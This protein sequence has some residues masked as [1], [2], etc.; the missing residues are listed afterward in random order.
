MSEAQSPLHRLSGLIASSCAGAHASVRI[1]DVEGRSV[2]TQADAQGVY[3]LDL[4]P[5]RAPLLISACL[6]AFSANVADGDAACAPWARSLAALVPALEAGASSLAHVNALT[7]WI[8]SGVAQGLGFRGPQGLVEQGSSAGVTLAAIAQA[9]ENLQPLIRPALL[10]LGLGDADFDPVSVPMRVQCGPVAAAL[11]LLVLNRGFHNDTGLP[12]ATLLFD[13]DYR[14]IGRVDAHSAP[15]PLDL[16]HARRARARQRD[17]AT[18]RL[19]IVGDSTAANYERARFPRTGWGQVLGEV[20]RPEV[21]VVNAAK[22]GRSSRSFFRQAY[23]AQLAP[24]MRPGDYL[25]INF[26]HNDQSADAARP[27]RGAADL[28]HLAT[29]PDDAV[30]HPQYPAGRPELAFRHSLER[31]IAAARALGVI[32]V[33]LTMTA[34]IRPTFP[35]GPTHRTVQGAQTDY[36]FVGDY[37]QTVRNTAQ[38]NAVPLIDLEA[39]TI[40]LANT[41]LDGW[42]DYWLAV[43]PAEHPWYA[44]QSTGTLSKPDLSHFQFKGAQWLARSIADEVR[45]WPELAPLA[46]LLV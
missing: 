6:P 46:G 16:Q 13:A 23:L 39:L 25:F 22:A 4:P 9:R 7:D 26:G 18:T 27:V 21:Q 41:N 17:P 30:G 40:Q 29:Y 8:V 38:A 10:E 36:A 19:F 42:Q 12:G 11:D 37:A 24:L 31:Y 2:T 15:E 32:P 1:V 45:R 33:L 34:R 3:A 44:T 14:F 35:L 28:A 5:L 43:D 20:F